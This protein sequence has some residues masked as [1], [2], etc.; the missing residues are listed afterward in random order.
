MEI[1]Q[2]LFLI[3]PKE[4]PI[5]TVAAMKVQVLAI[6]M[7]HRLNKST[8]NS[9]LSFYLTTADPNRRYIHKADGALV[10]PRQKKFI[11]GNSLAAKRR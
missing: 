6:P 8:A 2:R 9:Q 3:M 1:G 5:T 7:S 11:S 10:A 4:I